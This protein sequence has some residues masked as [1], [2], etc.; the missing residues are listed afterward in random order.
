MAPLHRTLP[1]ALAP[2]IRRWAR[3]DDLW[4]RRTSV[5]SQLGSGLATDRALLVDVVSANAS[6]PEFWLRKAI[7]WALR[8]LAHRDPEWVVAYLVAHGDELSPLSRREASKN[9]VAG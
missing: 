8:D 3:S 4:L 9:L 1:E 2:V 6:A 5:L 7:G